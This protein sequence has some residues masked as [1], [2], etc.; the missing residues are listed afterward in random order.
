MIAIEHRGS[1]RGN[2]YNTYSILGCLEICR[3][4]YLQHWVVSDNVISG[5]APT[6]EIGNYRERHLPVPLSLCLPSRRVPLS[7]G[8]RLAAKAAEVGILCEA[9]SGRERESGR[10]VGRTK[11]GIRQWRNKVVFHSKF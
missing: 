4:C 6:W 2:V 7:V 5:G 10:D 1:P 3:D 11:G 8:G 9:Q